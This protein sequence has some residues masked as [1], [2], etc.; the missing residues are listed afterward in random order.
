M[1]VISK[2]RVD[3]IYME[4]NFYIQKWADFLDKDIILCI[5]GLNE[6]FVEKNTNSSLEKVEFDTQMI[7]RNLSLRRRMGKQQNLKKLLNF[8]EFSKDSAK[9]IFLMEV[10]WE[11]YFTLNYLK[12]S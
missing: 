8:K 1:P 10:V 3:R 11:Y 7:S 2:K 12:D 9:D 6:I 5:W 4:N